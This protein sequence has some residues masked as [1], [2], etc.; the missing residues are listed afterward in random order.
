MSQAG[1]GRDS[2]CPSYTIDTRFSC[3][4]YYLEYYPPEIGWQQSSV[5]LKQ[6]VYY[7]MDLWRT[8]SHPVGVSIYD[9]HMVEIEMEYQIK[10]LQPS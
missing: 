2:R 8:T 7:V 1:N 3:S 6:I 4:G 10:R 5:T 9:G